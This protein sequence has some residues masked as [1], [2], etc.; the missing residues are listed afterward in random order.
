MIV[1]SRRRSDGYAKAA[2]DLMQVELLIGGPVATEP[3][4]HFGPVLLH[5]GLDPENAAVPEAR[6]NPN[7]TEKVFHANVPLRSTS[8]EL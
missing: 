8:M 2:K 5:K 7:G 4:M 3:K 1:A 6:T